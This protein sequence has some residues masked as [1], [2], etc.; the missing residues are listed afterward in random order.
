MIKRFSAIEFEDIS[1][2]G[3]LFNFLFDFL[4]FIFLIFA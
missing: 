4:F 2:D 3:F 1:A